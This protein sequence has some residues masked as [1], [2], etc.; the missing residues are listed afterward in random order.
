M[1]LVA[2]MPVMFTTPSVL[3][4]Q[5]SEVSRLAVKLKVTFTLLV[6]NVFTGL[7]RAMVGAAM[8]TLKVELLAMFARVSL[9]ENFRVC[10]PEVKFT[11]TEPELPLPIST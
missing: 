2:A 11:K 3:M 5:V 9:A 1:P 10:V 8:L 4:L 6:L 7:L